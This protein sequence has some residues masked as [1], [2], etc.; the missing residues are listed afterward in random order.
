MRY[1]LQSYKYTNDAPNDYLSP[2]RLRRAERRPLAGWGLQCDLL[3]ET[4]SGD[5]ANRKFTRFNPVL[6]LAARKSRGFFKTRLLLDSYSFS[7]H[8]GVQLS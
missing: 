1:G 5:L 2:P 4:Q 6:T 7:E 3:F 8:G